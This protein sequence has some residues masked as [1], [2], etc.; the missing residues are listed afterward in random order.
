MMVDPVLLD[1]GK[2]KSI[3][4]KKYSQTWRD[5]ILSFLKGTL[6]NDELKRFDFNFSVEE[7]YNK[8]HSIT[9]DINTRLANAR[10]IEAN[11]KK[12]EENRL[13]YNQSSIKELQQAYLNQDVD[14]NDFEE[15]S[16]LPSIED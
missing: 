7:S 1:T 11:E 2:V 16:R 6:S 5:N 4:I 10:V 12:R 14:N 13:K 8:G 15:G 9:Y 3:A